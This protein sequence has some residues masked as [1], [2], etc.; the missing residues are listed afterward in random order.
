MLEGGAN[1]DTLIGGFGDDQLTGGNGADRFVYRSGADG[2]DRI[3]GF[4][5][6]DVIDVSGVFAAANYRSSNRF[7]RYIDLQQSG[8]STI[9]RLDFNGDRSGGFRSV[10]T[11]E[12]VNARSLNAR[13]F[14][15]A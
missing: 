6:Q 10:L 9:V 1:A 3:V 15:L 13:S 14:V 12:N 7:V 8:S 2:I 11:L 5:R 4:D